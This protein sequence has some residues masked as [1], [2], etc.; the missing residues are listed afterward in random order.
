MWDLL[1]LK[2]VFSCL[3]VFFFC[4]VFHFVSFIFI[5]LGRIKQRDIILF[6]NLLYVA[7]AWLFITRTSS[8]VTYLALLPHR[9]NYH[10]VTQR[11][12]SEIDSISLNHWHIGYW[13]LDLSVI[14]GNELPKFEEVGVSWLKW[15]WCG[16]RD[17]PSRAFDVCSYYCCIKS[18][19]HWSFPCRS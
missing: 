8:V 5:L 9:V 17:N 11:E 4:V 12:R 1:N 19:S 15:T 18:L 3:F 10:Q 16:H 2:E 13:V 7:Q 14:F 6:N